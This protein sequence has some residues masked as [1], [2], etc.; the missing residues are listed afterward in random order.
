MAAAVIM[1]I[2]KR[3][4]TLKHRLK[5]IKAADAKPKPTQGDLAK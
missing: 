3:T 1:A 5:L 2:R 4:L